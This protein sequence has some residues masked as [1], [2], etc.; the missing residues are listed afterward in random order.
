M[1]N[2]CDADSSR[3]NSNDTEDDHENTPFAVTKVALMLWNMCASPC[4]S[5]FHNCVCC[6]SGQQSLTCLPCCQASVGQSCKGRCAQPG[7]C[8]HMQSKPQPAAA[9]SPSAAHALACHAPS[10]SLPGKDC[11]VALPCLQLIQPGAVEAFLCVTCH[12][13]LCSGPK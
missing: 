9:S 12:C 7:K 13:L 5:Y 6:C 10:C 8:R 3:D 1:S 2:G 11:T 4:G